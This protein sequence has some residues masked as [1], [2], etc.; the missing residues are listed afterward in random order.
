MW[1]QLIGTHQHHTPTAVTV[2]TSGLSMAPQLDLAKDR[3]EKFEQHDIVSIGN[4]GLLR[5]SSMFKVTIIHICILNNLIRLDE[6]AVKCSI[7]SLGVID[8]SLRD[9]LLPH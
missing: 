5:R 7:S 2:L 9:E 4:H 8:F 3:L 1:A 6:L